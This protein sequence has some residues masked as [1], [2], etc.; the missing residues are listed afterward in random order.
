MKYFMLKPRGKS[1]NDL[2]AAASRKAMRA[3]ANH[4][5]TENI[6]LAEALRSWAKKESEAVECLNR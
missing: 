4:I 5:Q 6:N 1:K 2:Y 3:Y